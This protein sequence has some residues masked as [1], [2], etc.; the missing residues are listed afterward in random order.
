[1]PLRLTEAHLGAAQPRVLVADDHVLI[2]D[3]VRDELREAGFHVCAEAG[4]AAEAIDHA[5][6]EA[7]DLCILDIS[8]PGSG[9]HAAA[10]IGRR[11]P[12]T[13]IV[14]LTASDSQDDFLDAIRAGAWGYLLKDG[15]PGRFAFALRDVLAGV[16]AFPRRLTAPLVVA[17]QSA[18]SG[19]AGAE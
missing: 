9:L 2:R 15:D 8:M 13:K 18:L 5:V 1:M 4:T 12:A 6:R 19:V 3:A 7:P 17:A 10:E 14:I 16:P 11:L